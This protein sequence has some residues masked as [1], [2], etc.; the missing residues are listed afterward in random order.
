MRSAPFTVPVARV[1]AIPPPESLAAWWHPGRPGVRSG[2]DWFQTKLSEIDENDELRI[3]WSAYHERWL[4]WKRTPRMVNRV[5]P[6]WL[7]LFV[8]QE[9]DGSYRGLDERIMARLYSA[10]ARLWGGARQYFDAMT[11]EQEREREAREKAEF[12]D[13]MDSAMESFYHSQ[14]STAGNGSKF[15]TYHS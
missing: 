7:L 13:T 5:S 1:G 12:N 10:S 4:V 11:R 15:S 2:P 8:V 9:P 14:I 6:G 3:T